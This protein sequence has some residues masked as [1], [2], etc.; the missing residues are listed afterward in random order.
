MRA[1][2]GMYMTPRIIHKSLLIIKKLHEDP[3]ESSGSLITPKNHQLPKLPNNFG[4]Y[5]IDLT[6]QLSKIKDFCF[7][8]NYLKL[9]L[10]LVC[11][12]FWE[13]T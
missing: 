10:V 6:G 4:N 2:A 11:K 8:N 1:L 13:L 7:F 3:S 5:K 12:S 9:N